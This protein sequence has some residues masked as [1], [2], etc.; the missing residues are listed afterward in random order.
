MGIEA[1]NGRVVCQ[2]GDLVDW[3]CGGEKTHRKASYEVELHP[4]EL[5]MV[6]ADRLKPCVQGEPVDLYHFE[7]GYAQEGITPREWEVKN[8][9][10]HRWVACKP[11]IITQ[12]EGAAPGEETWEPVGNFVHRYSYKLPEYFRRR[13]IRLDLAEHLSGRP[14]EV[15]E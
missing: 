5:H 4:G 14:L 10:G 12:W 3:P 7:A 13:G 9:L 8:I 1:Q 6:H 15:F 11:Q 2:G